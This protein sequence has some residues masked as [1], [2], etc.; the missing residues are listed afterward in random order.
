MRRKLVRVR[1][2]NQIT[3]PAE[4]SE[5]LHLQPGDYVEFLPTPKGIE[6]RRARIATA[7]TPEAEEGERRALEEVAAGRFQT[8]DTAAE[9]V[10]HLK[11]RREQAAA[12]PVTVGRG[13][14]GRRG[15]FVGQEEVV[16]VVNLD[17]VQK[18]VEEAFRKARQKITGKEWDQKLHRP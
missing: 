12:I 9:M 1:E 8:F 4:V 11:R 6:V 7:G 13:R 15:A 17:E 10:Q 5:A 14:R 18:M 3:L 2:R 16:T